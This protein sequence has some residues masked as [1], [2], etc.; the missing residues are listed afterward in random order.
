MTLVHVPGGTQYPGC[1]GFSYLRG[2]ASI[3]YANDP[4]IEAAN[5]Q[6]QKNVIVNMPEADRL[7]REMLPYIVEQAYYIPT[8]T[9]TNYALWWPWLKNFY[10]ETPVRFAV[11]CWIDQDLKQPMTGRR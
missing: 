11:Y 4:A 2:P 5:Q 8:P 7:Y 10:G 6:I 3:F 9:P 1:L